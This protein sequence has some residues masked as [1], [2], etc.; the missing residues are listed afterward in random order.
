MA[1]ELVRRRDLIAAT[2]R[3]IG[4]TGTLNVTVGQ[5]ARRA[6]VSPGLAFHYFG[7]KEALFLAAM[8]AI[9]RDYGTEI[10]AALRAATSPRG[11]IEAVLRASF[12]PGNFRDGAVAAWLNFYVLAQT[13]AE[14]QRLLTLY[15]RRLHSN[16]VHDLAPLL[17]G[18][19]AAERSA[20]RLAALIDGLYLRC[21]LNRKVVDSAGAEAQM[22]DALVA[23]LA[24]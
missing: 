4:E 13:S 9:L 24:R 12:A 3:E 23:E 21:A 17:G 15:H 6:G 18:R 1:K 22:L 7:D 16:L 19:A 8:R 5:I 14:A 2:I 11:R 20:V 10:R